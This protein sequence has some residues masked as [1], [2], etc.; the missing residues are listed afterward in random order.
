MMNHDDDVYDDDRPSKSQRKRDMHHMQDLGEALLKLRPDQWASLDLPERLQDALREA[1]RLTAHG[2]IRRQLQFIGKLMRDV[3]PEP[4]QRYLDALGNASV[5]HTAWLHRMERWRDRLLEEHDALT[6]LAEQY[7][8]AD[9]QVMRQLIRNAHRER[10]QNKPPKAYRELFQ[11][12]KQLE[13]EPG[14]PHHDA[15]EEDDD[16]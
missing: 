5:E 1:K 8:A 13:Q 3:E 11:Q 12:L 10:E 6:E 9:L 7:P 2:A 4:I 16:A 14:I 15:A